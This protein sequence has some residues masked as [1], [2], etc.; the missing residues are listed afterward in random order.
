MSNRTVFGI[1]SFA[2]Y[3]ITTGQVYGHTPIIASG[4]FSLSGEVIELTAGSSKYPWNVADGKIT[5]ELSLSIKEYPDFLYEIFMGK[6]PSVAAMTVGSAGTLVNKYGTS[7]LSGTTG[8]ASVSIASP[9]TGLSTGIYTVVATAA[10]TADVYISSD[11]DG[12]TLTD[13]D[14]LKVGS[15]DISAADAN[16]AG[17]KFTKGSGTI[18]F[19]TG[20]TAQFSVVSEDA[21]SV[22]SV[23]VGGLS[24]TFPYFGCY[25]YAQKQGSGAGSE[26]FE[27]DIFKLKSIGMPI[28]FTE[29]DWSE[30]SITAKASYDSDRLGVFSARMIK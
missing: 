26:I 24:D 7:V 18:A 25:L 12:I 30:M 29:S 14:T 13:S 28:V 16:L 27:L 5:A 8:I 9:A 6:A 10:D 20:H 23:T 4:E 11:I 1:H 22:S 19:V 15:I 17:I 3:D 21:T 2:P